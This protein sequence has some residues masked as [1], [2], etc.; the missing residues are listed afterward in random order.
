MDVSSCDMSNNS[1]HEDLDPKDLDE[2]KLL[3]IT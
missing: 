2:R 1:Y 3:I